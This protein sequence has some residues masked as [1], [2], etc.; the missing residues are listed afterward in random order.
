VLV[1]LL[2]IVIY[3]NS[4]ANK[5]TTKHIENIIQLDGAQSKLDDILNY[6]LT[7]YEH[8]SVIVIHNHNP[9]RIRNKYI[10][11]ANSSSRLKTGYAILT[12]PSHTILINKNIYIIEDIKSFKS[13]TDSYI[14]KVFVSD[15]HFPSIVRTFYVTT[16]K[17]DKEDYFSQEAYSNV[18]SVF[19]FLHLEDDVEQLNPIVIADFAT[20]NW[21][22]L[23][24]DWKHSTGQYQ[25][26][27]YV[28]ECGVVARH[29]FLLRSK[30]KATFQVEA[31]FN[32]NI[33][34]EVL[35]RIEI[36][37]SNIGEMSLSKETEKFGMS[38]KYRDTT[39]YTTSKIFPDKREL[40]LV[41]FI[42]YKNEIHTKT[43]PLE[44]I[45]NGLLNSNKK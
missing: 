34:C 4:K 6:C 38:T 11:G 29:G 14:T 37:N 40:K 20:Q 19:E 43:V 27:T 23:N 18:A 25:I 22:V 12:F 44:D 24:R 21:N 7:N 36:E 45:I 15:I 41:E 28:D 13:C 35:N 17:R 10:I 30:I 42:Q 39:N 32:V 16:V 26:P 2:A 9:R 1:G 8:V 3:N 33:D 5:K 31:I